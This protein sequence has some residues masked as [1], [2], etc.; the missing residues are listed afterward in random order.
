MLNLFLLA[1]VLSFDTCIEA[2]LQRTDACLRTTGQRHVQHAGLPNRAQQ[3]IVL[4]RGGAVKRKHTKH[5][6]VH[7]RK[8][9]QSALVRYGQFNASYCCTY[10]VQQVLSCFVTCIARQCWHAFV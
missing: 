9:S 7:K 6:H 3:Y 4:L 8:S 1:L 10:Y 2:A 5:K